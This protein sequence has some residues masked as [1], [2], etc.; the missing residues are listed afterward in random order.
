[1][2]RVERVRRKKNIPYI[3]MER[4]ISAQKVLKS[5]EEYDVGRKRK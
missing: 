3:K 5:E 1:M 4:K 2:K